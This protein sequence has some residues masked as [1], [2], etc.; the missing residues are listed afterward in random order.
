MTD[1]Q[2]L[3]N[4][5][6][7]F[8][9]GAQCAAP[10]GT[11]TATFNAVMHV[12]VNTAGD[13]WVTATQEGWF[14]FVPDDVTMPNFA[15]HFAVWFGLSDNNRNS[16]LHDTFNIRATATDGS[17]VTIAVHA[18]DHL[19]V[20]ASG[21]VN[22]FMD[23]HQ[24]SPSLIGRRSSRQPPVARRETQSEPARPER[25]ERPGAPPYEVIVVDRRWTPR[26]QVACPNGPIGGQAG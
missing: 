12:T 26:A 5:T 24:K 6:Q 13:V 15:G 22:L 7:T 1:T 14:T 20:S 23:C 21:Q 10:A 3:H 17:G 4:V 9:V 2:N 11:V 19:S 8:S 25:S 18:M 16:V